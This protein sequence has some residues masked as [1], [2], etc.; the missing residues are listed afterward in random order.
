MMAVTTTTKT[1]TSL[2]EIFFNDLF[3]FTLYCSSLNKSHLA[4]YHHTKAP[5]NLLNGSLAKLFMQPG[6]PDAAD[7]IGTPLINSLA[8]PPLN[9][10]SWG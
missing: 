10:I 9:K 3:P 2:Q 5:D 1:K 8:N 4:R 7:R 6:R